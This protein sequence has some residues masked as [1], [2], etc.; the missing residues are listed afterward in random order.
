ME[1]YNGDNAQ[2]GYTYRNN[3][4]GSGNCHIDNFYRTTEKEKV[5]EK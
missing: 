1:N 4:N 3:Y 2:T 5:N